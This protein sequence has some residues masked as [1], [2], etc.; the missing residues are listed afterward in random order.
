MRDTISRILY[1]AALGIIGA[2][3]FLIGCGLW[4]LIAG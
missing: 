1:I 2:M 3:G 4:L